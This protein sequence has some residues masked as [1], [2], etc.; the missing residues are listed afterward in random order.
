MVSLLVHI[1]KWQI[2]SQLPSNSTPFYSKLDF[3]SS[4]ITLSHVHLSPQMSHPL[5]A[6]DVDFA[7]YLTMLPHHYTNR[8]TTLPCAHI[9]H[10]FLFQLRKCPILP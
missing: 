10:K 2:E 5:S 1:L 9:C 6:S 7:S 3:Q 4:K 8:S